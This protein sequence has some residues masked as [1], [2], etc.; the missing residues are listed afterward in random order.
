[1]AGGSSI[2]QQ[3]VKNALIERGRIS[4]DYTLI[5]QAT[6]RS[7]GR[8]INE[9]RYAIALEKTMTK[10]EILTGYMNLAQ[11]GRSEYG[12]SR[13]PALLL[14]ACRRPQYR[15]V[16]HARRHYAVPGEV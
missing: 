10:D 14:Q 4:N 12:V 1:M 5:D 3:Y 2:T 6:E 13:S 9:A 11:F 15:R 7:I 8:K 16:C